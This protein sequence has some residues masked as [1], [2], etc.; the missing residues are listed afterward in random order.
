MVKMPHEDE[1]RRCRHFN[2]GLYGW[3][4]LTMAGDLAFCT[5]TQRYQSWFSTIPWKPWALHSPRCPFGIDPRVTRAYVS[6]S[7]SP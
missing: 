1:A 3:W 4:T 2:E 5:T 7:A 6:E